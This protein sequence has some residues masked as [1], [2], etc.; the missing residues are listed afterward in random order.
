[1]RTSARV[2]ILSVVSVAL[3]GCATDFSGSGADLDD[4]LVDVADD[5]VDTSV[6]ADADLDTSIDSSTDTIESPDT[7]P[8]PDTAPK[9]DTTPP[10]DGTTCSAPSKECGGSCV[11]V[12]SD[13]DN[14]GGCGVVCNDKIALSTC[15][16]S[17]CTCPSGKTC[18]GGTCLAT[19]EE[20]LHCNDCGT[21]CAADQFCSYSACKCRPGL[22]SC[23]GKCVDTNADV[24]NC[25][26]CGHVCGGMTKTCTGGKCA[27]GPC[28]SGFTTCD[29]GGMLKSC[30]DTEN[31]ATHCGDCSTTCKADELCIKGSC[32]RYA[33][34][35]GC[36]SCPCDA[37][38]TG[39]TTTCCGRMPTH[40]WATCVDG[41]D[42]PP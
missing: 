9:P 13:N 18:G 27:S 34:A 7:T 5:G 38:C 16:G 2:V 31:D 15:N 33:I 6:D 14:C 10:P 8:P 19:T 30:F 1:M 35:Y 32:T 3:A 29:A 36:T 23:G 12:T 24:N 41:P 21:A 11:D 4:A 37:A 17:S 40:K 20:P 25:G 28:P 22:T 26:M 39:S 42:C